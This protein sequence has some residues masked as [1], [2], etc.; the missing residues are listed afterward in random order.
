MN[1]ARRFLLAWCFSCVLAWSGTGVQAQ[2]FYDVEGVISGPSA[3][4]LI[5]IA[6]Y[7]EDQTRSR[8]AQAITDG[9][10]RYRFSRIGAGLYFIAVKPNDRRFQATEVRVEL[11]N[12][13]RVG[14]TS[15]IERVDIALSELPRP[16]E[17]MPGSVFIQDVPKAAE[18]EYLRAMES[19]AKKNQELAFRQL[20]HAVEI[21]PNYFQASE[22]LGLLH[23]EGERYR[24]AIPPLIKSI[25]I[26]PE[27]FASYLALGIASV[28]LGR[29]D[30]A[31]DALERAR[32]L[33]AKSFRVHFFLGIALLELNRLD[34]AEGSLK[35]SYRLGG[36]SRAASAHLHLA[37]LYSK[38][39][40]FREA[41]NELEE[42][43]RDNPKAGNKAEIQAAI[44]RMKSKL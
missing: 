44:V 33:D 43:L 7:L 25:E 35:E 40:Q 27:A 31:F 3:V 2:S 19:L 16:R 10:G 34:E 37:S 5:G 26:N 4:P 11:I 18:S 15:S 39:G 42:Y 28:R 1:Q 9:D 29:P 41:I 23:V 30:L 12:T 38:R 6:V 36:A 8:V 20:N 21:F 22:Q 32:R 24:E 13:A 17:A 14:S